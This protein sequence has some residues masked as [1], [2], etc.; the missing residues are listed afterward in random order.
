MKTFVVENPFIDCNGSSSGLL[1]VK[2]EDLDKA[3]ELIKEK[4]KKYRMDDIDMSGI[5][6]CI[7]EIEDNEVL[8]NGYY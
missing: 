5:M 2:A 1:V 7:R 4:F 3:E 6:Y 8:W